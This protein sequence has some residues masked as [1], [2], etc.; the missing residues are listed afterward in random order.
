ML[1]LFKKTPRRVK[2]DARPPH[3]RFR[4]FCVLYDYYFMSVTRSL[5]LSLNNS[6]LCPLRKLV[7]ERSKVT[8]VSGTEHVKYVHITNLWFK[9]Y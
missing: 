3:L 1:T 4:Q 8:R 7:L 5:K 6:I 9:I 2:D